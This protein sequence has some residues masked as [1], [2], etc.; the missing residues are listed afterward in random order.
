ME[1]QIQYYQ[2]TNWP[3]L[4]QLMIN[5]GPE[6]NDYT[7]ETR[8]A[9]YQTAVKESKTYLATVDGKT[10]GFCRC[11]IDGIFGVYICDL[12]VDKQ[13]RGQGIAQRLMEQPCLEY[14]EQTVYV[15]S[16]VDDF[17][18]GKGYRREGSIFE[19]SIAKR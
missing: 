18:E 8:Q 4:L 2:E 14:P 3:D 7:S 10:V 19:V 13:F 6:W 12:L 1:I 9:A 15:M 5:E 16:D 11:R 17:Y